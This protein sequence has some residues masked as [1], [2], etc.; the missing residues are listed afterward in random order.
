MLQ[1]HT[2]THTHTCTYVHLAAMVFLKIGEKF[3]VCVRDNR[4]V[5]CVYDNM[6]RERV[7]AM[8]MWVHLYV[9]QPNIMFMFI[10]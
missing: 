10:I 6:E 1:Y 9:C 7:V 5:L 4:C 2:H 3:S 8:G